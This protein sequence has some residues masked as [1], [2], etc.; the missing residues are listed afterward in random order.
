MHFMKDGSTVL[1]LQKKIT[2]INDFHDKV[3]WHLASALILNYY[4]FI[5]E[6]ENKG[7][8]MY[9]SNLKINLKKFED[10]IIKM[11]NHKK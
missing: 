7:H 8:D 6:P 10:R 2:N 1:E 5:C 9:T 3:L 4:Y 11:L